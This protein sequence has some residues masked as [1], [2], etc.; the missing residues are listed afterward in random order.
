MKTLLRKLLARKSSPKRRP[1]PRR[2][3]PQVEGLEERRVMTVSFHG[4][5][6]LPNVEATPVFYGSGWHSTDN[7]E[8]DAAYMTSFLGDVVNSPFMDMLGN[9][10]YGVGRGSAAARHLRLRRLERARHARFDPAP[11]R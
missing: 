5:S 7:Y 11:D 3:L 1:E 10:G 9:A 2:A 6:V 4:G 8:A